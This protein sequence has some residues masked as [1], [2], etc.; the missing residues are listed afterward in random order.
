MHVSTCPSVFGDKVAGSRLRD[1]V[2]QEILHPECTIDSNPYRICTQFISLQ[3]HNNA[4]DAARLVKLEHRWRLNDHCRCAQWVAWRS[5]HWW[6]EMIRTAEN[7]SQNMKWINQFS[8]TNFRFASVL[9]AFSLGEATLHLNHWHLV[10]RPNLTNA[11]RSNDAQQRQRC[12]C[13]CL[14]RSISDLLHSQP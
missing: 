2:A 4:K 12:C 7:S 1:Q 13:S 10:T 6:A 8:K 14:R 3:K 9:C 11:Y 5:C